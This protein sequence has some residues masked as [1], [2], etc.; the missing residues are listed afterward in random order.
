MNADNIQILKGL[1]VL[2]V[3]DVGI[4]A[5][6]LKA[7]LQELGCVV[8]ATAAR[9]HEAEELARHEKLDGVLL[10]L[11][12]A[13]QYSF[14]VADILRERNV[15]FIIMSGYDAGQLRPDL[16]EAPQMAKPFDREALEPLLCTV[17][18]PP[19]EGGRSASSSRPP[20]PAPPTQPA[21]KAPMKTLGELEAAVCLGMCQF[22][23]EYLGRGPSNVRAHLIGDLL[24]IRLQGAL[25]AAEQHLVK[26]C[27]VEQGRDLL[28]Q[29]RTLLIETSRLQIDSMIQLIT[30][31]KV[32]SMHQDISTVT[33]EQVVI[34]T[35]SEPPPCRK[36]RE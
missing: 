9:L 18:C 6:S 32:I 20:R 23:Q 33:G 7:M 34:F 19:G 22:L 36:A 28:K 27:S 17:L 21:R 29:M 26:T 10:D 25:T 16:A 1:R 15:P 11:N 3:E 5:M 30:G 24:V 35:L 13:G 4:V 8:V 12:L 2:V 14:P 31:V